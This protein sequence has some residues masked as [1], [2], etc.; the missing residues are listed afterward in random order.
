MAIQ[1]IV[2]PNYASINSSADFSPLGKLGDQYQAYQ[3]RA[4][5]QAAL[6]GLGQGTEPD[7][8]TLIRSGD[9]GLVQLGINMRNRLTDQARE[10]VRYGVTD[11]RAEEQLQL[12]RN[13]DTRAATAAERANMTPA[14][15]AAEK[16][17]ALPQGTDPASP[18]AQRYVYGVD[19]AADKRLDEQLQLNRNADTRAAAAA[20]RANMTPAQIAAEKI[21]SLPPGTDPAS[22]FA[23]KYVFG[24]DPGA[25]YSIHVEEDASGNKRLVRVATAGPEGPINSGPQAQP[26]N[27]LV[28]GK[29]NADQSKAA[30]FT[31]R[32]AKAHEIITSNEDINQTTPWGVPNKG[33]SLGGYLSS[34]PAVRD[35]PIFNSMIGP[36]RQQTIQAQRDFVNAILRKESGAAI[37]QGEF[38]NAEKQYFPQPG[39]GPEVIA[40]KRQNRL[41]AMQSM[42]REGG[43]GYRPPPSILPQ[44]DQPK[45]SGMGSGADAVLRDARNAIAAGRDP[46]IVRQRLID[47][48]IDP[49]DL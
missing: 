34:V 16:I 49:K 40:Q 25:G 22:P 9:A 11:K 47:A 6:A 15:I 39:D 4:R 30:G 33:S 18:F 14:E 35:S 3:D 2:S 44:A 31:D 26:N 12:S 28:S 19:A 8:N 36:A 24:V 27:P 20:A 23:Q 1:P 10:D 38:N 45:A 37:S 41:T 48:G 32:M 5:K 43:P 21:A 17:A 29:L 46:K 7:A 42:A 13:A